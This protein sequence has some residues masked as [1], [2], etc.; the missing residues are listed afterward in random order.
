LHA[1]SSSPS[2]YGGGDQESLRYYIIVYTVGVWKFFRV[3]A[4]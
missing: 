3:D 4:N 1:D 2:Y